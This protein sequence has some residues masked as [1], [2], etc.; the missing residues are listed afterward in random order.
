VCTFSA[1]AEFL[2]Q[3]PRSVRDA[4]GR[5]IGVELD[6]QAWLQFQLP[7]ALG[8]C[9]LRVA[10]GLYAPAAFWACLASTRVDLGHVARA[11]CRPIAAAV[12]V[13]PAAAAA[14]ALEQ[15]GV[16][17]GGAAIRLSDNLL[18]LGALGGRPSGWRLGH[19]RGRG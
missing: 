15:A 4:A 14:A 1:L 10:G 11:L 6:G 5:I 2:A 13:A 19:L 16:V 17:G 3:L 7:G 8:G 18:E 9:V 12:D